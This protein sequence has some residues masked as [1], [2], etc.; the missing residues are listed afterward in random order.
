MAPLTLPLRIVRLEKRQRPVGLN[1]E[2]HKVIGADLSYSQFLDRT[3]SFDSER[4]RRDLLDDRPVG[5]AVHQVMN[6]RSEQEDAIEGN[7]DGGQQRGPVV[8]RLPNQGRPRVRLQSR[9]KRRPR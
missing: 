5:H 1:V 8:G 7:H 4:G 3:N 9:S 6:R 2:V